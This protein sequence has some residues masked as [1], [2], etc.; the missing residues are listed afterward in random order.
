ME[1]ATRYTSNKRRSFKEVEF[2]IRDKPRKFF[3]D[4][5]MKPY[6]KDN[7]G[8]FHNPINGQINGLFFSPLTFYGA[9]PFGSSRIEIPAWQMFNCSMRLYFVDFYCK[10]DG[11]PH[12]VTLVMTIGGSKVDKKWGHKLLELDVENNWFLQRSPEGVVSVVGCK[13]ANVHVE[14]LYT[15]NINIQD[16]ILRGAIVTHNNPSSGTSRPSG[17]PKNT[18]CKDCNLQTISHESYGA[19]FYESFEDTFYD[20][21]P[22]EEL[23]YEAVNK[24]SYK[25]EEKRSYESD[26]ERSSI[27]RIGCN[28]AALF[29][30]VVGLRRYGCRRFAHTAY[31]YANMLANLLARV[32]NNK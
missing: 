9:S 8:D 7:N 4:N 19:T 24:R 25:T 11:G 15:H 5:V 29:I 20:P 30:F 10:K 16:W 28:I 21:Y 12:Y 31:R 17:I 1:L 13:R 32:L 18:N 3:K 2:F 23:Y 6:I 22:Y 26:E 14:V 27:L